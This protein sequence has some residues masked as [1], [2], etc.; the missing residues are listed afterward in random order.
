MKML[1]T[2]RRLGPRSTHCERHGEQI[3]RAHTRYLRL[4]REREKYKVEDLKSLS[5]FSE[6]EQ[7]PKDVTFDYLQYLTVER[8]ISANYE[9]LI[10]KLHSQA[11]KFMYGAKTKFQPGED[12]CL[13]KIFLSSKSAMGSP[14]MPKAERPN[15]LSCRTRN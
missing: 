7:A 15:L 3:R 6:H 2:R 12:A 11:A 1:L 9:L 13:I 4:A 10:Q 5:C 8:G 14:K